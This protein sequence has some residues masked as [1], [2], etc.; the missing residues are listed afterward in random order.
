MLI[1]KKNRTIHCFW[2]NKDYK[3]SD[4]YLDVMYLGSVS[5][6]KDHL[7]GNQDD[8]EW[9]KLIGGEDDNL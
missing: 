4:I 1:N 8:K 6:P 3:M 2:C 7:C 9:K 5:C